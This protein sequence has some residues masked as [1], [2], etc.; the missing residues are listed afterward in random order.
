MN[1]AGVGRGVHNLGHNTGFVYLKFTVTFS[2][3]IHMNQPFSPL[4]FHT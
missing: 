3:I 1:L 2:F 4:Y